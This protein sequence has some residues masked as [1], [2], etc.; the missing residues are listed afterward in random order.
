MVNTFI[1]INF[2]SGNKEKEFDIVKKMCKWKIVTMKIGV[3]NN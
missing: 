3:S 1:E 2:M